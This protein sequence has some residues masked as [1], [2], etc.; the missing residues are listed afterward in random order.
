MW[1]MTMKGEKYMMSSI[2]MEM[3][4]KSDSKSWMR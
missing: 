2:K 3:G 1:K 4:E